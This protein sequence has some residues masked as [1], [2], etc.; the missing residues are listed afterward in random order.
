M[1]NG[2]MKMG[3]T[4]GCGCHKVMPILIIILGLDLLLGTLNVISWG[5][6]NIIWPI[7]IIIAGCVKLGKRSCGC[8][9]QHEAKM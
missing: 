2:D 3:K 8:W 9:A 1:E 5:V 4:C 6:V 7:L